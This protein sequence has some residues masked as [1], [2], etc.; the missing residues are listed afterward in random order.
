MASLPV[1]IQVRVRTLTQRGRNWKR[2][3][4]HTDRLASSWPLGVGKR[5][6]KHAIELYR[7]SRADWQTIARIAR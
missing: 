3:G 6:P 4:Q 1:G 7:D 2:L 5:L